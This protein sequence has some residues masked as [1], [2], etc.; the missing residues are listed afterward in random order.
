MRAQQCG[1][2]NNFRAFLMM[3]NSGSSKLNVAVTRR[4]REVGG[5]ANFRTHVDRT[6]QLACP[7]TVTVPRLGH[8]SASCR[9]SRRSKPD[10]LKP[11]ATATTYVLVQLDA[12]VVRQSAGL[13]GSRPVGGS[14]L[15]R[16]RAAAVGRRR[17]PR[18]P[19]HKACDNRQKTMSHSG[20]WGVRAGPG[21]PAD[22]RDFFTILLR[23]DRWQ[24]VGERRAG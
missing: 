8:G 10:S 1:N 20:A 14:S 7:Q 18:K 21:D 3:T 9:Q 15:L 5:V 19:P 24:P 23:D 6:E 22:G 16:G 2:N 13:D 4:K 17:R 11:T 12:L